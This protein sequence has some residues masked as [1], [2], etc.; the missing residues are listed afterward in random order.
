L[1]GSFTSPLFGVDMSYP[2]GWVTRPATVAWTKKDMPTF[3]DPFF[4]VIYDGTRAN[5]DHLFIGLA[6]Q[7]LGDEDAINWTSRMVS[8]PGCFPVETTQVDDA[9]GWVSASCQIAAVSVDGR[10]YVFLGY[11]SGDEPALSEAYNLAWFEQVLATVRLDPE[12]A[13]SLLPPAGGEMLTPGTY[14]LGDGYGKPVTFEVP[15]GWVAC[16]NLPVEPAVCMRGNPNESGV[17]FQV[18]V[19]VVAEPCGEELRDP[20]VGPSVD[21]LVSAISELR[22]FEATPPVDVTISGY[23][24]KQFELTAPSDAT[25]PLRTWANS[26]RINGVGGGEVNLLRVI[27]VAGT[28]LM[29]AGAIHSEAD[30]LRV[31][32][33]MD[34]IRIG[35]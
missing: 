11:V 22:G 21:D 26:G 2:A 1:T 14:T 12:G 28:R 17:T 27:D 9:P 7:P 30:R 15:V 20:P 34:S 19:N 29:I 6:S 5:P 3:D 10:G 4:D 25:C 8:E 24:G 18:V 33:F 23:R 16:S 32:P 13:T 31:E 35:P